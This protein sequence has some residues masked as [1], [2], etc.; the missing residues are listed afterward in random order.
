MRLTGLEIA[1][2]GYRACI[3]PEKGGQLAWLRQDGV[4]LLNA[5][6]ADIEN[7]LPR[8]LAMFPMTPFAGRVEN[9]EFSWRGET[10]KLPAHADEPHSL[11][12]TGWQA[13]WEI[14][15]QTE[16]SVLL[17]HA[18]A[19]GPL[20][21]VSRLEY[22]VSGEGLA[23]TLSVTNTADRPLPFGLGLHPW[24]PSEGAG[25]MRFAA[26]RFWLEAPGGI[27]ADAIS[28]PP[29]LD[30][31]QGGPPFSHW[32]NNCYEGWGREL[33]VAYPAKDFAVQMTASETLDWLMVF[34]PVDWGTFCLEPQS[35]LPAAHN[36]AGEGA[37]F[38]LVELAAGETLSGTI[39]IA[40]ITL[41]G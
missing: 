29:E 25:E 27:P 39:N 3:L 30:F 26:E 15:E 36:K 6:S 28:L 14:V 22:R 31:A 17:E 32:R 38:G 18:G 5:P 10:Y 19:I 24:F 1:A 12:G 8:D 11:H 21:H 16:C 41:S 23:T 2:G 9:A 13:A 40:T 33:T 4:D 20:K 37:P 35:Q 7:P 34:N